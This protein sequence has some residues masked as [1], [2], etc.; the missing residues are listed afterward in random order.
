MDASPYL[1][2]FTAYDEYSEAIIHI[3]SISQQPSNS[4]G[5]FTFFHF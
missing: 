2:L 5:I 4:K 3:L 1:F